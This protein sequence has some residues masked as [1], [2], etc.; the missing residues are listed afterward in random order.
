VRAR[1]AGYGLAVVLAAR[2]R[3]VGSQSIGRASPRR[4]YYAARNHVRLV[5]KLEPRRGARHWARRAV[6]LGRNLGH[7]LT[8]DE[9]PRLGACRAVLEGFADARRGRFGPRER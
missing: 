1:R 4:L 2:A 3:H 6:V 9:A 8:Q 5:E 7:A